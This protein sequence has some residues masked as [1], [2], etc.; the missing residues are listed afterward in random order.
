MSAFLGAF[1]EELSEGNVERFFEVQL[2]IS[3]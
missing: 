2:Q 3:F 1:N